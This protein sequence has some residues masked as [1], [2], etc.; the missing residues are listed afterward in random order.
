M[1]TFYWFIGGQLKYMYK[2]FL[3]NNLNLLA[4]SQELNPTVNPGVP[5]IVSY[6]VLQFIQTFRQTAE[7]H[8]NY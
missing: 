6:Y 8:T 5:V 3:T 2:V 4:C 7:A 1:F